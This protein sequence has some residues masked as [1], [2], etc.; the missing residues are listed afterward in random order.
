MTLPMLSDAEV[1]DYVLSMTPVERS[2]IRHF[3]NGRGRLYSVI[4]EKAGASYFEVQATGRKLQNARLASISVV[5]FNGCRLFLN[6]R[7]E[8]IK[9]AV[10]I[11][12][13]IERKRAN[14]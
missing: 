1:A 7:G 11:F 10:E 3:V 5:P 8:Q 4:A 2:V 12:E 14:R 9:R 13:E 6:H